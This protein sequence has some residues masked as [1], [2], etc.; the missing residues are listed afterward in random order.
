M[1][2]F[3]LAN[4]GQRTLVYPAIGLFIITNLGGIGFIARVITN[5]S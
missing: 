2:T 1:V 4:S 5:S 3:R